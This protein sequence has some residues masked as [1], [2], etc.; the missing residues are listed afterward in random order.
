M[1]SNCSTLLENNRKRGTTHFIKLRE[2]FLQEVQ[3]GG[4]EGGHGDG[5]A[6]GDLA[7]KGRVLYG[8]VGDGTYSTTKQS[9]LSKST[10]RVTYY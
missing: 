9:E 7:T 1:S 4:H 3:H 8:A 2:L 10:V 6:D 5:G